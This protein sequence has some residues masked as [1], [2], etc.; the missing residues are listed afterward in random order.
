MHPLEKAEKLAIII[1]IPLGL[2]SLL[3]AYLQLSYSIEGVRQQINDSKSTRSME[4]VFQYLTSDVIASAKNIINSNT[5]NGTDYSK[6]NSNPELK[7]SILLILNFLN[8]ISSGIE[9]GV[10]DEKLVC[11]HLRRVV[12]KQVTVHIKGQV[13][14]GV[15]KSNP[16]PYP[17]TEFTSLVTIYDHWKN[18]KVCKI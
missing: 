11:S 17:E 12:E 16:S 14:D 7:R 15:T 8:T 13:I 10:Y 1:G 2:I 3:I 18:G 9:N 6:A 4:I 5:N